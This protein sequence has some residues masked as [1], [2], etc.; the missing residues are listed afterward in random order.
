MYIV[1]FRNEDDGD[2]KADDNDNQQSTQ[3]NEMA[4]TMMIPSA[5]TD[6]YLHRSNDLIEQDYVALKAIPLA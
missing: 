3:P 5:H 6:I 1:L 4:E 2:G